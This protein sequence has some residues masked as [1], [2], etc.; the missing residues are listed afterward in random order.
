MLHIIFIDSQ[1]FEVSVRSAAHWLLCHNLSY[2]GGGGGGGGGPIMSLD[3]H[4]D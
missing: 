3:R 1:E 2:N 4:K